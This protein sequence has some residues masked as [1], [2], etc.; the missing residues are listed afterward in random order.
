MRRNYTWKTV[1][2]V[3][4]FCLSSLAWA[5][6]TSHGTYVK[7]STLA[8]LDSGANYVLYGINGTYKGAMDNTISGGKM[9]LS[10]V[11]LSNDTIINP[12]S[13]VVWQLQSNGTLWNLYSAQTSQY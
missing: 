9:G 7:V 11:H 5:S 6:T 1:T 3:L 13:S 4:L 12:D 8:D 10:A 2:T